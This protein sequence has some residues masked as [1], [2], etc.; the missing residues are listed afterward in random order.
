MKIAANIS[1][2][3]TELPLLERFEAA[4]RAGF[5]GVEIQ[6]PYDAPA[7]ALAAAAAAAEMPVVLINAPVIPDAH[8]LG[9]AARPELR[10]R[11]LAQL[12]TVR[13]YAETLGVRLVHVLAGRCGGEREPERER[14]EDAYVL[15][16]LDASRALEGCAHVLIEVLNP[17]DAPG[18][19]LGS[20]EHAQALIERCA[21]AVSLQFDA[22][23]AA[24]LGLSPPEVLERM[25]PRVRHVQIADSPGRHEPGS[26]KIDFDRILNVLRGGSYAGWIGAEYQPRGPTAGSLGWLSQW[27]RTLARPR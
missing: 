21:G 12:P 20:F 24:R 8:P 4:R 15:N 5:D 6:Y 13:H 25:L 27:R 26:G 14:C 19:F 16:L 7:A 2:L 17:S 3:F 10:D 18:Y 22:Y 9:I 1:L 23:H 11:F